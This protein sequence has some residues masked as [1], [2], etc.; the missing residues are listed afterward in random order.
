MKLAAHLRATR[1]ALSAL[2][3]RDGDDAAL[4]H[5]LGLSPPAAAALCWWRQPLGARPGRPVLALGFADDC[6]GRALPHWLRSALDGSP[7][8][9]RA[10]RGG[11]LGRA[12]GWVRTE[13]LSHNYL[14]GTLSALLRRPL[15]PSQLLAL[16]SG[17]VLGAGLGA[18]RGDVV[19]FEALNEGVPPFAGR[20]FDWQ[21]NFEALPCNC[22]IDAALVEVSL[23]ALQPLAEHADDFPRGTASPLADDLLRLRTRGREIAGGAPDL[24]G[25][26]L[27]VDGDTTRPYLIED[28]LCW[29]PS[30]ETQAGDSGA[31]VWNSSDELVAI[32]AGAAPDGSGRRCAVAVPIAPILAW[33]GADVV[34]RGEPLLR[35]PMPRNVPV[36]A[37]LPKPDP[38]PPGSA[39]PEA[40]TLA[41]TMWGEARGELG[42]I[43]GMDAVA[44]V[45]LNR[46][47]AGKRYWGDDVVEVCRKPWQFSCWNGNDPNP[48]QLL[49]ID[50]TNA[51]FAAALRSAERLIALD[52]ADPRQR[53]AGDPTLGATHYFAARLS[54]RPRWAAGREPCVRIGSH[55]FFND[56][57]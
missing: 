7:L 17:H 4:A 34:R 3:A 5:R 15:N 53:A 1:A 44:H 46:M 39:S 49:K 42:A 47:H 16:T 12:Q 43:D 11:R 14:H 35:A 25:M 50:A 22:R 23:A 41:R 55:L 51:R 30:E 29:Y 40:V 18:A 8:P 6:A 21:P 56:I 27:C 26:R 31:P 33:A 20:L 45:V 13:N 19:A 54:P 38:A 24:M 32:H 48:P 28:A 37:A 57:P 2:M 52:A 9:V 36:A 10:V